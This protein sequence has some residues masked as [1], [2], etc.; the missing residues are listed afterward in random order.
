M[1]SMVF[2]NPIMNAIL[3]TSTML[4]LGSGLIGLMGKRKKSKK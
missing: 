4:L 1:V 2:G 3:I